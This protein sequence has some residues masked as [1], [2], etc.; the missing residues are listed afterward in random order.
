MDP[1]IKKF[2]TTMQKWHDVSKSI[3]TKDLYDVHGTGGGGKATKKTTKKPKKPTTKTHHLPSVHKTQPAKPQ[4]APIQKMQQHLKTQ[5]AKPLQ[6][7]HAK[8][9]QHLPSVHKTQPAKPLQQ[10]HA[11]PLQHLPPVHKTQSSAKPASS[12]FYTFFPWLSGQAPASG[13]TQQKKA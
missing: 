4:H 8:P 3:P 7:Q 1:K 5:P 13:K 10:Q 2:Q 6:Q 11:K 9:L 12:L